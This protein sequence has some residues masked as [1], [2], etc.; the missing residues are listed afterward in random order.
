[1]DYPVDISLSIASS[2]LP[3][4][5]FSC[6]VLQLVGAAPSTRGHTGAYTGHTVYTAGVPIILTPGI[7]VK[8]HWHQYLSLIILDNT[9][10]H[11]H[12]TA[13]RC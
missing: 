13:L 7:L 11:L 12:T 1:M 3:A 8:S 4:L 6:H 2:Q 10:T 9:C 5:Y